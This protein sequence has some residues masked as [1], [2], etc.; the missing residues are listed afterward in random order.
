MPSVCRSEG[1]DGLM[2]GG[3]FEKNALGRVFSNVASKRG[4]VDCITLPLIRNVAH[5]S[6]LW[7]Y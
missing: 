2:I 1:F 6:N 7:Y 4:V 3:L 5:Q